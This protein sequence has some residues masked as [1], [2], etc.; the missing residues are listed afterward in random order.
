M[1]KPALPPAAGD[2]AGEEVE[3]GAPTWEKGILCCSMGSITLC[4][5][6]N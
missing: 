2:N 1:N 3:A 5:D 4:K 6:V